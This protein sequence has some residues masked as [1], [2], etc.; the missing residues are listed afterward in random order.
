M[1]E[2]TSAWIKSCSPPPP[3]QTLESSR[4]E[5]PTLGGERRGRRRGRSSWARRACLCPAVRASG[6]LSPGRSPQPARQHMALTRSASFEEARP[7]TRSG[8]AAR[9]R[10][11]QMAGHLAAQEAVWA[12]AP[13]QAHAVL[14]LPLCSVGPRGWGPGPS[15][16]FWVSPGHRGTR[17]LCVRPRRVPEA[18]G[19][20][21]ARGARA[22]RRGLGPGGFPSPALDE[23]RRPAGRVFLLPV[24]DRDRKE[25]V[26]A[27]R[28]PPPQ[29]WS[30]E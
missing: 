25:P 11:P 6:R 23:A 26:S 5:A 1:R 9:R 8:H 15:P 21:A 4:T 22:G 7:G 12:G 14:P 13:T 16:R 30:R 2:R 3:P 29:P 19:R 28:A 24:V 27:L 18:L 17:R 20:R 10:G